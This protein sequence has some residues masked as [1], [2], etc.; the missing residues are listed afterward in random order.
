MD[1]LQADHTAF[2]IAL[3]HKTSVTAVTEKI[4][5]RALPTGYP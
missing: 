2:W 3:R 5:T 1:Y 4:L